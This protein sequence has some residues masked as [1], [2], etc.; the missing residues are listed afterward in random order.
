MFGFGQYW[1]YW[2]KKTNKKGMFLFISFLAKYINYEFS[3][4]NNLFSCILNSNGG[5]ER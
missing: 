2:L 1:K 5:K 4:N 3:S